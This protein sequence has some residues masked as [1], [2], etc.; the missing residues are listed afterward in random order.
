MTDMPRDLRDLNGQVAGLFLLGVLVGTATSFAV[1]VPTPKHFVWRVTSLLVP[2]YLVGSI[3]NLDPHDYPLPEVYRRAVSDSQRLVFECD[4]RQRDALARKFRELAKYP[5]GQ[6]IRSELRPTTV[7]LLQKNL[8]RFNRR[9]DDVR[10]YR[11]WAIALRLLT[12]RGLASASSPR[13]MDFYFI[14]Q[15]QRAGK[16]MAGLETIDEH[17][18]F[19]HEMLERDGENLLLYTLARGKGVN[20]LFDQTRAAWKRGDVAA[21]SATNA[22]LREANPGIAQ[23]LLDLRNLKWVGRIEAEMKTGKPTAIVAGAGHFS[24][25]RSVIELLRKRGYKIEQL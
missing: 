4:P 13:S 11:P 5:S 21:L 15:A 22:G 2:F 23:R 6:D 9:F 10:K 20:D 1:P 24:G 19:W 16:E 3:H 17:V 18:A 14:S 7:A 8:W 25:S 12:T